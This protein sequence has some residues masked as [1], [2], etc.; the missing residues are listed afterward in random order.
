MNEIVIVDATNMI[1]GRLAARIAKMLLQGKRVIV[2][3]AEKAVIS[4]EKDRILEKYKKLWGIKT[5][6]NPRKGPF[7]YSRPDLFLKRRIRGM[8][9]FKKPRGRK[10]F[11]RLRVFVGTPPEFKKAEKVVF[12]DIDA[13]KKLK[14]KWMTVGELLK[15]FGWNGKTEWK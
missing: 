9:P 7:H 5:R 12:E 15:Y 2:I 8:L 1:L 3:N 13:T 4:G 14:C 10:A 11:R 6:T